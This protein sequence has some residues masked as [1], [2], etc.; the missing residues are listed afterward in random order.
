MTTAQKKIW[1]DTSS[2]AIS[3][4]AVRAAHVPA[5][6]FKVYLNDYEAGQQFAVKA[7]HAFV[8][9]VLTGACKTSIDGHELRLSAGEFVTMDAGSYAFESLGTEA[10]QLMKVFSRA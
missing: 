6:N 4:E 3:E 5:E 8:L 9:Y 1:S 10:L 2:T 7:G